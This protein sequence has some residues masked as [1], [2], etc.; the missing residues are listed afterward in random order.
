MKYIYNVTVFFI[1]LILSSCRKD[2]G[3]EL[4]DSPG[5]LSGLAAFN[6]IPGTTELNLFLG[7]ERLNRTNDRFS[8]GGYL[9]HRNVYPGEKKLYVEGLTFDGDK[10]RAVKDISLAA[11]SIYSLFLYEE[12]GIQTVVSKDNLVSP[13][14]GYAKIRLAHMV[15]DAPSLAMWN[16]TVSQ[17]TFG[18]ISFKGVTDFIEVRADQLLSLKIKPSDDKNLLPEITQEFRPENK[19]IYTLMVVGLLNPK[20][21][22][23]EVSL[24]LIKLF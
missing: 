21:D 17:P 24:R 23:E 12:G 16:G 5:H 22:K 8:F 9:S 3:L 11:G 14:E 15:K 2:E 6:A 13:R 20:N 4:Y 18:N 1:I 10:L 7:E 19:A